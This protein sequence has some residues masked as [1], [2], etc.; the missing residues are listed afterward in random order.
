[1]FRRRGFVELGV[2][3]V[4]TIGLLVVA[5]PAPPRRSRQASSARGMTPDVV[6]EDT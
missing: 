5:V 3:V 2:F 6:S 4:L 1:V